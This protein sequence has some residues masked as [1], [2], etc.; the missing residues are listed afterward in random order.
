MNAYYILGI[1]FLLV[2]TII[3]VGGVKN[4]KAPSKLTIPEFKRNQSLA[5]AILCPA[6]GL[7]LI[8]KNLY[9]R[10]VLGIANPMID[11][12]LILGSGAILYGLYRWRR[13]SKDK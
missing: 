12:A 8:G 3:L 7:L 4:P 5:A 6:I 1:V 11:H 2:A 10:H 9:D 13:M